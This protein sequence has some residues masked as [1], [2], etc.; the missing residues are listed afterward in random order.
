MAPERGGPPAGLP[1][2]P[3]GPEGRAPGAASGLSPVTGPPVGPAGPLASC[4]AWEPAEPAPGPCEK[5]GRSPP[6]GEPEPRGPEATAP[7]TSKEPEPEPP[8][9]PEAPGVPE[10]PA[11]PAPLAGAPPLS[12]RAGLRGANQSLVFSSEPPGPPEPLEPPGPPEPPAPEAGPA[13][14]PEPDPWEPAPE[15]PLAWDAAGAPPR[16]APPA[17][18]APGAPG[19][20]SRRPSSSA[21]EASPREPPSS[22]TGV[23]MTTGGDGPRAGDVDPDAGGQR[24]LGL[25]FAGPPAV[26][27]AVRGSALRRG[28]VRRRPRGV[29]GS[30]APLGPGGRTVSFTTQGRFSWLTPP[31]V[32]TSSGVP[33]GRRLGRLGGRT[34]ILAAVGADPVTGVKPVRDTGRSGTSLAKSGGGR[35]RLRPLTDRGTHHSH[36]HAAEQE[37][38]R[39]EARAEEEVPLGS[40]GGEQHDGDQP[41]GGGRDGPRRGAEARAPP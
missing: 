3:P 39:S 30:T 18:A 26:R 4:G 1:E 11:P 5:Y 19:A 21:R 27:A 23:R 24:G 22:P 41:A 29:S 33:P 13:P 25:G 8:G 12:H 17:S 7:D 10:P 38:V 31:P 14:L 40:G 35:A 34:T 20:P 36:R 28:A 32:S 37:A 2:P 9:A 6:C 16:P 15:P